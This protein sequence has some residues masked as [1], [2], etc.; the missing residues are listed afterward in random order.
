[1]IIVRIA[2]G[3]SHEGTIGDRTSSTRRN[4]S[5]GSGPFNAKLST[6]RAA[7]N[8]RGESMEM[9]V[10]DTLGSRGEADI[11]ND[12]QLDTIIHN[13]SNEVDRML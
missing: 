11:K 3:R 1:M 12:Y 10:S 9:T 2:L 8:Y 6:F 7:P 5:R 13:Q 4:T